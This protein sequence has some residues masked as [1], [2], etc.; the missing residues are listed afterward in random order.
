MGPERGVQRSNLMINLLQLGYDKFID[1]V[2][3]GHCSIAAAQEV[4]C[5]SP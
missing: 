2:G 3:W 5:Y 4:T 1:L